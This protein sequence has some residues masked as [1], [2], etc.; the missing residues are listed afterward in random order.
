M[1]TSVG[2]E[3][4][5]HALTKGWVCFPLRG[6][7]GTCNTSASD[8]TRLGEPCPPSPSPPSLLEELELELVSSPCSSWTELMWIHPIVP[9]LLWFLWLQVRGMSVTASIFRE[10][11]IAEKSRPVMHTGSR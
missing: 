4:R 7:T 9:S 6:P 5:G 2:L 1:R 10:M 11:I 8:Y 3:S